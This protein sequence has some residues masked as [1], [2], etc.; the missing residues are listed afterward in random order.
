MEDL[1]IT[2][3]TIEPFA[4]PDNICLVRNDKDTNGRNEMNAWDK[5]EA[6]KE[7]MGAEVV[8]C[9]M[10]RKLSTDMLNEL[11]DAIATDWDIDLREE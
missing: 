7:I 10:A 5:F 1:W 8:A 4:K 2:K 3:N 6:V 11:I 9:D